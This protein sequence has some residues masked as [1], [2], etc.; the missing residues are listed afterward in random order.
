MIKLYTTLES[1]VYPM[2]LSV[3]HQSV[4][5]MKPQKWCP[6]LLPDW[7][8]QSLFWHVGRGGDAAGLR[9]LGSPGIR[10]LTRD[11]LW[12]MCNSGMQA[13]C[14]TS[15]QAIFWRSTSWRSRWGCGMLLIG[16][17]W[18]YRFQSWWP[19]V[20]W[21]MTTSTCSRWT[22]FI[23]TTWGV[24]VELRPTLDIK[25]L[26][27][28]KNPLVSLYWSKSWN[29]LLVRVSQFYNKVFYSKTVERTVEKSWCWDRSSFL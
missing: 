25:T 11:L 3:Q 9:M 23:H 29:V 6:M 28:G 7:A 13:Y 16:C 10:S 4:K 1:F 27:T 14:S 22:Q 21:T 5:A 12:K 17:P 15:Q 19:F 8:L 18:I 20:T 24:E 2:P 26:T